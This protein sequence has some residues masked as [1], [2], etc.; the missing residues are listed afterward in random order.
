MS[1]ATAGGNDD[2][3]V[4]PH[5]PHRLRLRIEGGGDLLA[6]AVR[7]RTARR[8]HRIDF[9]HAGRWPDDGNVEGG[10]FTPFTRSR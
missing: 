6:R 4:V 9:D 7:R 8:E 3:D 10:G 5:R 1:K 2:E